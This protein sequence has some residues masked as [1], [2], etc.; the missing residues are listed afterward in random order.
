MQCQ[1]HEIKKDSKKMILI[2]RKFRRQITVSQKTKAIGKK[3]LVRTISFYQS[4]SKQITS[5]A[6]TRAFHFYGKK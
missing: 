2:I 5:K 6:L 1:T 4:F 3:I